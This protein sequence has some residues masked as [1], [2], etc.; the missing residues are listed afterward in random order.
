MTIRL[1]DIS[2]SFAQ[3]PVLSGIN[4]TLGKKEITALVGASGSGKT[5]LLNLVAGLLYP[6]GGQINFDGQDVTGLDAADRQIGYVFQ[7]FAL[8]PH[9]N[10]LDNVGFG[11]RV[12]GVRKHARHERAREALRMVRL[13]SFASQPVDTL[14]GGQRQRVALARA[15]VIEPRILLL[16]EPLSALDPI[17]RDAIRM[18]L[19]EL[20]EPLDVTTL[21]VTHDQA[22]AFVLADRIIML[23]AGT[24]VQSGTSRDLYHAPVDSTVARF[25]GAVNLIDDPHSGQILFRP[26]DVT[27]VP[28]IAAA[29]LVM[30]VA[31]QVFLGARLR[32]VG[33]TE[34]GD[35]VTV[36]LPKET[37]IST[38]DTLLLKR[39]ET[40]PAGYARAKSE[41]A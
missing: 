37:I 30:R 35:E 29:N 40:N 21:I 13:E 19:R 36:D 18:E 20:L 14:S 4:L 38:G 8:F 12:R 24:I 16:D 5:T 3:T 10:V 23:R 17:L 2:M 32:V 9:L 28:E 31:R 1:T 22:D 25:F 26:E 7:N 27:V 11:L 15:L 41:V 34:G 6:T 33:L 39:H